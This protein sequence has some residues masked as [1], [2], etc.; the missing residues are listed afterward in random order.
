MPTKAHVV[1]AALESI[2]YQVKDLVDIM[3]GDG[4]IRLSDLR[5]D[6]GPTRNDFLM[7]FQADML[8]GKVERSDIEEVS[9][10]G[11]TFLAGLAFGFWKDLEDLKSLRK[12]DKLFH[13]QMKTEEVD[14]LYAGWKNAVAQSQLKS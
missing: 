12:P 1:R 5:V 4:N 14:V 10:L 3:S 11:S 9:A 2:A 6:G 8:Q 13:P 7:Q